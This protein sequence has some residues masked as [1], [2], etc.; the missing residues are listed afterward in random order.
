MSHV[1]TPVKASDWHLARVTSSLLIVL[2][3]D[4]FHLAAELGVLVDS[5]VCRHL[6]QPRQHRIAGDLLKRPLLAQRVLGVCAI[7]QLRCLSSSTHL[8]KST[9]RLGNA[10]KRS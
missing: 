10:G 4:G 6:A 1:V 9:D 3:A 8:V 2:L 5:L 7:R